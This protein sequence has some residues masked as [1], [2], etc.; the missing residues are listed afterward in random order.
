MSGQGVG[1]ELGVIPGTK[2]SVSKDADVRVQEIF[3]F[4]RGPNAGLELLCGRDGNYC[5]S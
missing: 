5:N 1:E 2:I 4:S 3:F